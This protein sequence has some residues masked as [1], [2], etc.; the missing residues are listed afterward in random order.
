MP[1]FYMLQ[2]RFSGPSPHA[3]SPAD[4]MTPG[5]DARSPLPSS[6]HLHGCSSFGEQQQV[7]LTPPLL[8]IDRHQ[9]HT[10]SARQTGPGQSAAKHCSSWHQPLHKS[11]PCCRF[12]LSLCSC[13][14][15]APPTCK[16]AGA[17]SVQAELETAVSASVPTQALIADWAG[18]GAGAG[19]GTACCP[20]GGAHCQA[21]AAGGL[22]GSGEGSPALPSQGVN[23]LSQAAQLDS[24]LSLCCCPG[25]STQCQ[26]GAAKG[27][28]LGWL[29]QLQGPMHLEKA[30]QMLVSDLEW[31]PH[32][33][34]RT[35]GVAMFSQVWY[36]SPQAWSLRE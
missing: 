28:T 7:G 13:S 5:S 18:A 20:G 27:Y 30:P 21:G 2:E 16:P 35:T 11:A 19:Q 14:S 31:R 23:L 32:T 17:P 22:T 25:G 12:C 6:R 10:L 29:L 36:C 15:R 33:R 4:A 26:A 1:A 34:D 9:H 8:P 3:P 24:L